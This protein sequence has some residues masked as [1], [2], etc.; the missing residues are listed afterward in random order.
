M[1]I[2]STAGSAAADRCFSPEPEQRALARALFA[3]VK[4]LPI[5][6][7]HG[8]VDPR[9]LADDAPLPDP[10]QL[11]IVPDHY[12]FRMLY[13]QGVPM[14]ELGVPSRDGSAV[15][16][17]PRAI[18]QRF[19][20]HFH[21]FRGTPTGL[22]L[23][24]E[25]EQLFEIDEKLGGD[26]AQ[27]I[28]DAVQEKLRQPGYRPRA[29]FER[30]N[31]HTLATTDAA[32]DTLEHHRAMREQGFT[33]VRPTF[34]PDAVLNLD[35]EGWRGNVERLSA[36]SGIAV[37]D[38]P[39]F[40]R[41]LEQ[42]RAFFKELGAAATDHASRTADVAPLSELEAGAVF[43]RALA[44]TPRGDDAPRFTAH[45]LFE[46]ARM[47]AQDGLVMQL[48]VGSLRNHNARVFRRFGLDKG[49]D[50][51]LAT[52]WTR[53]LQPLM[54][55]YGNDPR[56]RLVVYTLDESSYS[57]ELAPMAGHYP[58]LTLGAPWWFFDS[59]KG[60]ERYLDAVMETAGA[61]NLAGFNDDTRA[62]ASIP[63]RHEVWRRV[64]SNWLA[65]QCVRGLMDEEDAHALARALAYEQVLRTYRLEATG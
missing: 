65:G 43:E 30:F 29:L 64:T 51:P 50:I 3:G 48:H 14:E 15:E 58:A 32:T 35:A 19:A 21:L 9:M 2:T 52:E 36:V 25:L 5:V 44:G 20:E 7:P 53:A 41:A 6:G 47:S 38:Y 23:T 57:R 42:R 1:S 54:N 18:W 62:F 8:H 10:A 61:Y 49:A 31:I 56:Y 16:R 17:D 22:W 13:S 40:L 11:F 12:V 46:M 26:N 60:M 34:R 63:A 27:R 37:D 45:M 28:Y 39:S 59:V 55:A 33:K 4:D 24:L